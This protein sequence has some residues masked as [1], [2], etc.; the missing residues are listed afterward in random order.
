M[1][2]H[3]FKRLGI[4]LGLAVLGLAALWAALGGQPAHAQGSGIYVDKRLGRSDPVVYV[5]EYITFTIQIRNNAGF[6]VTRLPLRDNFNQA[7]LRYVDASPVGPDNQTGGQLD[8][9]D[10][11]THFGN[12]SPGQVIW[13]TVGFIAEHPQTAIVNRA[14]VHDAEGTEG[15]IGG[16]GSTVTDTVA[17]G[18]SAPVEKSIM[19]G[20]NPQVGQLLTFTI[21]ITNQGHVTLTRVPLVDDYNPDWMEFF[22]ADPPPDV[23]ITTTGIL[24]WTN[25]VSWTGPIA[26]F[27]AV[28]ITTVFTALTSANNLPLNRAEVEA[29][30]DWYGNDWAGGADEVPIT[31]VDR[32]TTT[33]IP[34]PTPTTPTPSTPTPATPAPSTPTPATPTP[35]AP[36]PSHTPIPVIP[37]LP[38][39][40]EPSSGW[41]GLL[42]M[43]ALSVIA[44]A[45]VTRRYLQQRKEQ[46][47][48]QS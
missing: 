13:L 44:G 2:I 10:L 26:P 39:T 34:T 32:P 45:M 4:T 46:T 27:Q 35:A 16:G 28:T 40:G 3:T 37:L 47:P 17:I 30:G 18:G 7:V 41:G 15:D 9:D 25:I 36:E 24:S 38:L 43:A 31:I 19:R 11:T 21:T 6:T 20:L 14:E 23:V 5:G 33:P 48:L 12:L 1:T 42:L 8:W 22:Y 29:V